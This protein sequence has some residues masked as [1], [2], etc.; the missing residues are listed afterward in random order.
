MSQSDL[1]IG[2]ANDAVGRRVW[3]AIQHTT[4]TTLAM[5]LSPATLVIGAPTASI[6]GSTV[7]IGNAT[8]SLGFYGAAV[9]TKPSGVTLNN[10]TSIAAALVNLGLIATTTP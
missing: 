4:G 9:T 8:A 3:D 6:T 10:V 2:L 5:T 1:I 7:S